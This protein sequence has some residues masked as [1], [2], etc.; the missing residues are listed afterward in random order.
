MLS[1]ES[2][3][4]VAQTLPAVSAALPAISQNFYA[5]LFSAHPELLRDVFNR[6][7]QASGAQATALAGA[8]T[9]FAAHVISRPQD[10]PELLLSRLA[11][12]HAAIGVSRE[13]Y[14]VVHEH[15]FGAIGEVLGEAVTPAV[16]SAWNEVYW[17]MA[18]QLADRE[19]ALYEQR[20]LD[21]HAWRGWRDWRLVGRTE[22]TADITT[23][24]LV[25]ADDA[26]VPRF[27]PGQY[28][29]VQVDLP[30]GARQIRQ[31]SLSCGV[32]GRPTWRFS[33]KRVA[34]EDGDG[35]AGEVSRHLH[36]RV[37]CGHLVSLSAPFG[38]LVLP[39]NPGPLLLVSAGI[40]AA[41]MLSLLEH[42]NT[43]G[44]QRG[45]TA[46]HADRSHASH[47]R[48]D[49]HRK[50]AEGLPGGSARFW[51]EEPRPEHPEELPGRADLTTVEITPGTDAYVCGPVP[52]LHDARTQLQKAG[53]ADDRIHYEVFG[54]D[55]WLPGPT[56]GPPLA[57]PRP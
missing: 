7:N 11:H 39:E 50:L 5:R 4:T 1:S 38:D 24:H 37:E 47:M 17:L 16:A 20:V 51:Y 9:T 19:H 21:G 8:V 35:S 40:G 48:A 23:F 41:P 36:D 44:H 26:A 13:Q 6:A 54:P 27:V 15:L 3:S 42:L 57:S 56:G 45:V 52:F 32:P 46:V 43:T 49:T 33:V 18:D 2:A 29:S 22:E 34:G 10:P 31:Y 14:T 12:R 53:L 30:D 55:M 28:V 25:P